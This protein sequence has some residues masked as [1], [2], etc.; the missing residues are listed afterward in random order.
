[1]SNVSRMPASVALMALMALT[2]VLGVGAGAAPTTRLG[3]ERLDLSAATFTRNGVASD[4][5]ARGAPGT[6]DA[7][8]VALPLSER[9]VR[10]AMQWSTPEAFS[11]RL[12]LDWNPGPDGALFEVV[13]D[14]QRLSP[15][16]DA[17]RPSSRELR[18]DLGAAWLGAGT[19]LLEFVAREQSAAAELHLRAL[20]MERL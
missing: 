18:S 5:L 1:M 14:G 9:G 4:D 15:V 6:P 16:R 10:W 19:H 12:A 7:G 13:L 3:E 17:W 11:A 20:V 8:S 2:A